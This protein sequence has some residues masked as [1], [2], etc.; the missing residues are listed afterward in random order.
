MME[1]WSGGDKGGR[2]PREVAHLLESAASDRA[3][4]GGKKT[5][6]ANKDSPPDSYK[7]E[8]CEREDVGFLRE[9]RRWDVTHR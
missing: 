3:I 7:P 9:R 5:P 8:L 4:G 6:H 1:K 2:T